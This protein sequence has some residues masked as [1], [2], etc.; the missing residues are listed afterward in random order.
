MINSLFLISLLFD[1]P[2]EDASK[3]YQSFDKL[4]F[5]RNIGIRNVN[6]KGKP[7]FLE[8]FSY[9]NDPT[10]IKQIFLQTRIIDYIYN[11]DNITLD[12]F[13][14]SS[15]VHNDSH[16]YYLLSKN[17]Y[18]GMSMKFSN[19]AYEENSLKNSEEIRN[20]LKNIYKTKDD[21][22]FVSSTPT[23]K[24][25]FITQRGCNY[26]K[27]T[28]NE[29]NRFLLYDNTY[30]VLFFPPNVNKCKALNIAYLENSLISDSLKGVFINMYYK[31]PISEIIF[32]YQIIIERKFSNG[33]LLKKK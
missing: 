25:N 16:Q 31:N 19:F 32:N 17:K 2:M 13:V 7:L 27:P 10:L 28:D 8:D 3:I 24:D 33:N 9:L 26:S 5:K 4:F 14:N 1:Y 21:I 12:N 15:L 22:Y 11:S 18:I 23:F 6:L 30:D 20:F 29:M